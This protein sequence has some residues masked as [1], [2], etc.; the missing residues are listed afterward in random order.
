MSSFEESKAVKLATTQQKAFL[1]YNS[2]QLSR[3]FPAGGRVDS[4]N[5]DPTVCWLAGC[6]IVALNFQVRRRILCI[7]R[8]EMLIRQLQDW[9]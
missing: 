7:H 6:Q 9:R 4:S 8:T 3:I 2:L 1:E 5:Y